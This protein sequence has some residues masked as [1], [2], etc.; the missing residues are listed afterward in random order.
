MKN[1]VVAEKVWAEFYPLRY[2]KPLFKQLYSSKIID[3]ANAND[4]DN[5]GY[6]IEYVG[7]NDPPE[8]YSETM[9]HDIKEVIILKDQKKKIQSKMRKISQEVPRGALRPKK[10]IKN[11]NFKKSMKY[12]KEKH[13]KKEIIEIPRNPNIKQILNHYITNNKLDKK[14]NIV[15]DQIKDAFNTILPI[16]L[17][18]NYEKKQLNDVLKNHKKEVPDLTEYYGIEHLY[19]LITRIPNYIYFKRGDDENLKFFEKEIQNLLDFLDK[20]K[21]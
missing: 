10:P 17:L 19:R 8:P 9:I 18:F 3:D 12:Q 16:K 1:F 5:P 4:A 21:Y 20:N 13:N 11:S 2:G 15:I 14:Q 7:W 6:L